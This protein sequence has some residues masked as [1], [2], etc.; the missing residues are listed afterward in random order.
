MDL[1]VPRAGD[2]EALRRLQEA[3]A[4]TCIS[5]KAQS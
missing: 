3:L 2:S 4:E 5:I 1:G